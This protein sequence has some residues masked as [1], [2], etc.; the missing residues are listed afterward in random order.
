[1]LDESFLSCLQHSIDYLFRF[2]ITH[3]TGISRKTSVAADGASEYK[4]GNIRWREAVTHPG[5]NVGT[6]EMEAL[7]VEVKHAISPA[8]RAPHDPSVP[9]SI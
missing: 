5:E 3:R 7:L 1:M 8:F 6:T 2:P 9:G 4:P